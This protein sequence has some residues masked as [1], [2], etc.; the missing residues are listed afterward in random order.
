[1]NGPLTRVACS[2]D[3]ISRSV[4]ESIAREG[5]RTVDATTAR[6]FRALVRL[7]PSTRG[8]HARAL[9]ET[10]S[11]SLASLLGYD[12]SVARSTL[13]ELV[14][15][16]IRV[17]GAPA[18]AWVT[19]PFGEPLRVSRSVAIASASRA[20]LRW[21]LVT[22]GLELALHDCA[23]AHARRG[24]LFDLRGCAAD[25]R[26]LQA[27]L[28]IAGARSLGPARGP[29]PL[30]LQV[31]RS[32]AELREVRAALQAGVEAAALE[33]TDTLGRGRCQR[34]SLE[35]LFQQSLTVVY[36]IL[37]LR[38]A[39]S[40]GLVPVWHPTY[41]RGYSIE[42]LR[43]ALDG[44]RNER[45]LWEA[46]QAISRLA[47]HGARAGDLLIVP[48]NGRL[49]SPAH[50]PIVAGHTVPDASA[51][52]VLRALTSRED[53]GGHRVAI[54]YADLGVEQL[55]S[56]YERVLELS[57]E[58]DPK[59]RQTLFCRSD[60]RKATGSF[61]T[62]RSLTEF[63]VRRTLDPL[64]RQA[65]SAQILSLKVLDAAMGS[66]A[67]LVAAC[68]ELARAYEEAL[69]R[70]GV[71]GA[72][73]WSPADRAGFRRLVAQRCLYGVDLNP[74]AVQLGRL[75]LWLC[76]LA[77]DK[78]LTFLD[79]RLR[80]GNSL[81]GASPGDVTAR[82]PGAARKQRPGTAT[83][84]DDDLMVAVGRAIDIRRALAEIPD[85]SVAQVH[86]KEARLAALDSR[87][88]PISTWRRLCDLWCACW[89]WPDEAAAPGPAEFGAMCDV[90]RGDDSHAP[91]AL[92]D[93]LDQATRLAGERRFFHW[94]LE[95]PEAF[96]DDGFDAVIGNPP[97][98][99]IRGSQLLRQTLR[100]TRG[101]GI[102]RLQSS[103]HANLYQLFLE[104]VL[105]LAKPGGRV[106]L[107]L[108]W[109]FA[110]D[111]GSAELRRHVLDRCTV[112]DLVALD[113][114]REIFPVHRALKFCVLF[115]R[116]DGSSDGV[117][118]RAAV[119]DPDDLEDTSLGHQSR[120]VE[121]SRG[122]LSV[123]SGP[124]LSIPYLSSPAEVPLLEHLLRAG[125]AAA[126][127]GGWGL[128]FSRELNA[129]DDRCLFTEDNPGY[130]VISGRH[131][132]P[133]KVNPSL[134][135]LRISPQLA[136]ERLGRAVNR[137]RLAYR[138][139]AGAG[140][141]V[142]LIAAIV[143]PHV[144]T[145]HTL[146][147]LRTRLDADEQ[148]FL[149]AVLNS[150]VANYLVRTRVGTHVTVAL[151]HALPIPRPRRDSATFTHIVSLARKGDSPELQAA[152]AALYGLDESMFHTVLATFP[153][154]AASE[155]S[156]A[157]AALQAQR[158]I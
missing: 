26:S 33:L 91:R 31:A 80:V 96:V 64:T 156:A 143:P 113:N 112:D 81:L 4:V 123:L 19:T 124:S 147:C 79:H 110:T 16:A 24:L 82:A 109:G 92:A 105:Q 111:H 149:C 55:G 46:L 98:D 76:S 42:S 134:S 151:V 59:T 90:L 140:N 53:R 62:P 77:A 150:Y 115:L 116:S 13:E 63:I 47:H 157:G 12:G 104:R 155:R 44:D 25:V 78:P 107:V 127:P 126:D 108:P 22:N 29:C 93:R 153:L 57:P 139:V 5:A 89:F 117:R 35:E 84:F 30:E 8:V 75:S 102:Y 45:G 141:R 9:A 72:G 49:F 120:R 1:M 43:E 132:E 85:D 54:G 129:S 27:L 14:V 65:S 58:R 50:S 15:E 86:E 40:R 122:F 39:E 11:G 61:Y 70:E 103:G 135:S 130:P 3:L 145:T 101:S 74:M 94:R 7:A 32:E 146:F 6:A 128:Q 125:R 37:F 121:L 60:V 83:L 67:F 51:A 106:G 48:F 87:A 100:F 17:G 148:L 23:R 131:I 152:L 56:I 99:M 36:R 142:T 114:R 95:F 133:F 66:G 88:G 137:P 119:D 154:I 20:G 41:R 2:G 10:F 118:Y 138:D 38:F 34:A 18:A 71:A 52:A 69:M 144:V 28:A 136:V 68:R 97:W 21:C 158:A 73:D